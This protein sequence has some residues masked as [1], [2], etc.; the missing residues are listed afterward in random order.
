[1]V[2]LND[3]ISI[4]YFW[5]LVDPLGKI[6]TPSLKVFSYPYHCDIFDFLNVEIHMRIKLDIEFFNGFYPLHQSGGYSSTKGGL[7]KSLGRKE[8][9]E[10]IEQ[11][12]RVRMIERR[13]I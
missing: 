12:T 1:M 11:Y 6:S 13:I 2:D 5:S 3:Y 8:K 7:S 10:N 4:A 9:E